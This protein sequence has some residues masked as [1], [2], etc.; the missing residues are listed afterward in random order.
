MQKFK[1]D[2]THCL[3]KISVRQKFLGDIFG[4]NAHTKHTKGGRKMFGGIDWANAN[5]AHVFQS[6][7]DTWVPLIG[8][9]ALIVVLVVMYRKSRY[10]K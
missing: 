9:I 2:A 8:V 7:V 4:E 1:G 10:S 6:I 5:W 3:R